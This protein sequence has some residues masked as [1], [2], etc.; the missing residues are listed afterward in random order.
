MKKKSTKIALI[1]IMGVGKSK[2]GKM[3]AHQKQYIF[4]DTDD[5]L[6]NRAGMH[7]SQV[8]YAYG[9]DVFR[10]Y[11]SNI[12]QEFAWN[13]QI[14]ISTGGGV[15]LNPKN[16]EFIK[17]FLIIRLNA[18][19]QTI[20]NRLKND[21]LIRPLT[22]NKSDEEIINIINEREPLYKKY[23]DLCIDT[24]NKPVEQVLEEITNFLDTYNS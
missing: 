6:S 9:E 17:D 24:D 15:V 11:E 20:L 22:K 18:A 5:T 14:V 3:L 1:G 23:A 12:L 2:V 4:A 7:A 16:M 19:P 21:T 8:F 10:K 13:D